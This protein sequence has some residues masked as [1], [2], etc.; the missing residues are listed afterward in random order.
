VAAFGMA[1]QAKGVVPVGRVGEIVAADLD[2]AGPASRV[3]ASWQV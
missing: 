3:W 1:G 2:E